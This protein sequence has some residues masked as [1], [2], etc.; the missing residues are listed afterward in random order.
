M[1]FQNSNITFQQ[2]VQQSWPQDSGLQLWRSIVRTNLSL[3]PNPAHTQL[4]ISR[5]ASL[6]LPLE[7]QIVD[8]RGSLKANGQLKSAGEGID[9]DE[10]KPG[11]YF[12][13][14]I[15]DGRKI[16]NLKFIKT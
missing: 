8:A 2:G 15:E 4:N 14:L 1:Q 3:Y 12:L 6:N 7:Y 10:L 9:V 5:L 16:S 11:F 13:I